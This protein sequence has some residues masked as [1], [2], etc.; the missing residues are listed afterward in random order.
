M[1]TDSPVCSVH[2]EMVKELKANTAL[3]EQFKWELKQMKFIL[4]LIA[5]EGFMKYFGGL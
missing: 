1:I 4:L 3:V 2:V 5:A